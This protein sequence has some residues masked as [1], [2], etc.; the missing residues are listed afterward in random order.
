MAKR[1]VD[2]LRFDIR[3]LDVHDIVV[4]AQPHDVAAVFHGPR[5]FSAVKIGNVR[6]AADRAP[7]N[8]PSAPHS[9]GFRRAAMQGPSGRRRRDRLGDQIAAEP[10]VP[11]VVVDRHAVPPLRA[12]QVE[13]RRQQQAHAELFQHLERHIVDGGN[14]VVGIDPDR[15]ERI[16]QPAVIDLACRTGGDC[17]G[18]AVAAR[19]ATATIS[20]PRTRDS[21]RQPFCR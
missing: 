16:G 3:A 10:A 4:L 8:V 9:R 7:D 5:P 2:I 21:F 17:R 6:R 12:Q 18:T 11:G 1:R 19:P 20:R 13:R 15:L 14:L